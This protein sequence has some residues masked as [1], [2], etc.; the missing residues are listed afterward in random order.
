[1][2]AFAQYLVGS[3]GF[4][5]VYALA[6]LGLV[7]IYKTSGVVNFAFGALSAVVTLVLW[8]ALHQAGWPLPV[9]WLAAAAVALALGA[10]VER[11]LLERIEAVPVLIQIVLTLGLLLL[12][13]GLAGVLWGYEPKSIPAVL[14]GRPL[15]VGGLYLQPNDLF[16]VGVTG[17]VALALWVVLERTRLGLAMRAVAYDREI[18]QAMGIR[19]RRFVTASWALGVLITSLAAILVAPAISLSPSMM[20]NVAVFAFAAAILGGFGSLPGA[21]LGGFLIGGVANLIAA[22]VSADLQLSLVFLLIVVL[23][24]VR[25]QGLLGRETA[26]RQ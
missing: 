15:S 19:A 24:Y 14:S 21:V 22:Y 6:A 25:P 3:L 20:D 23:L 7:L 2:L 8:T 26:T 1:M 9:S 5:G 10:V 16:I 17:A 4:G 12:V 11:A 13:E 18:A